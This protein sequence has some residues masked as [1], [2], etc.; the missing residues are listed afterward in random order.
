MNEF[1]ETDM[2]LE[3]CR[4]RYRICLWCLHRLR[5]DGQGCPACRQPLGE[6][7]KASKV[8]PPRGQ[9]RQASAQARAQSQ[10][11]SGQRRVVAPDSGGPIKDFESWLLLRTGVGGSDAKAPSE[12]HRPSHS[13]QPIGMAPSRPTARARQDVR[14]DSHTKSPLL[15]CGFPWPPTPFHSHQGLSVQG[16]PDPAPSQHLFPGPCEDLPVRVQDDGDRPKHGEEATW[17]AQRPVNA[18]L[19]ATP[20][21]RKALAARDSNR[22]EQGQ[23]AFPPFPDPPTPSSSSAPPPRGHPATPPPSAGPRLSALTPEAVE[24]DT[25]PQSLVPEEP[26]PPQRRNPR[27]WYQPVLRAAAAS[28]EAQLK[29]QQ[30]EEIHGRPLACLNS[31]SLGGSL[32]LQTP[33]HREQ[34]PDGTRVAPWLARQDL[35]APLSLRSTLPDSALELK[36]AESSAIPEVVSWPE[37]ANEKGLSAIPVPCLLPS[38]E[39]PLQHPEKGPEVASPQEPL[40]ARPAQVQHEVVDLWTKAALPHQL[41]RTHRAEEAHHEAVDSWESS[42]APRYLVDLSFAPLQEDSTLGPAAATAAPAASASSSMEKKLP[43][44]T[45]FELAEP[46]ANVDKEAE[47]PPAVP[48]AAPQAE[49]TENGPSWRKRA[50]RLAAEVPVL[51]HGEVPVSEEEIREDLCQGSQAED[52]PCQP[53]ALSCS[54]LAFATRRVTSRLRVEPC[55]DTEATPCGMSGNALRVQTRRALQEAMKLA[56]TPMSSKEALLLKKLL[57]KAQK[58]GVSFVVLSAAQSLLEAFEHQEREAKPYELRIQAPPLPRA[59]RVACA[60]KHRW[61]G[62][63]SAA[64]AD[65]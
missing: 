3:P 41:L 27:L 22:S 48:A 54:Q 51:S 38:R 33:R 29:K 53:V 40:H 65:L 35:M 10:P 20:P 25:F 23:A 59:G 5:E 7:Q 24:V 60:R 14:P 63:R 18:R 19:W 56:S 28:S 13:G 62:R 58:C 26:S 64:A 46:A 39:A 9:Q 8:A 43:E 47:A 44:M 1:D 37:R 15:H 16:V 57:L 52:S 6:P 42:L 32:R 17:G 45:R 50:R 2:Q 30:V 21:L 12:Q 31:L 55:S 61:P 36:Q 49:A 4:C 11:R 34:A